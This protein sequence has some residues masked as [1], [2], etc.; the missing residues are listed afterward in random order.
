MGTQSA[1]ALICVLLLGAAGCAESNRRGPGEAGAVVSDSWITA[2]VKS[3]LA[4][5][6]TVSAKR[7]R[8]KT[9]DGVVT[10]SGNARSLEEVDRAM[11]ATRTIEGVKSVI[12]GIDVVR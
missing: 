11:G 4:A 2:K 1:T 10:L 12:N 7:I 5:D 3:E 6:K 8:V 9:V